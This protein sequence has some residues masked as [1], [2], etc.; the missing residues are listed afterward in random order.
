MTA[1]IINVVADIGGTNL[2]VGVVTES[3]D[4]KD[5][6]L[7]QCGEHPSLQAVLEL[8]FNAHDIDSSKVNACLAIACPVDQDLIKMTNLPWQ[9]SK[10]Q[11]KADLNLNRLHLINDYTAIAWAVP[12]L[13]DDQ[14]VKIGGGEAVDKKP[15]A[16]CGPGTGLGVANVIWGNDQW[17]SVGGEGGHADFA[18][19]DDTE[20]EILRFLQNKYPRVSYEQLLS[21][22]GIEQIYQA[23]CHNKGVSP[24]AYQAKD[25]SARALDASC[26]ICQQALSQF[27]KTLGSFAGNLALTTAAFGGIYIAGG[28]VPRFIEFFRSSEFRE[29]FE[30]KNRFRE[31]NAGIPTYVITESQPGILGA[32]AYLIQQNNNE[33]L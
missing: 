25:I 20:I 4:V 21:G 29:R 14:K 18:A 32:S 13:S 26:D 24:E 3:G 15:I 8:Y 33:A 6:T 1:A 27:C 9:F 23:L 28:I 17:V 10:S 12:K 5:L 7:Y 22:L 11:L 16:I 31:F 30:A 2:R 19:V